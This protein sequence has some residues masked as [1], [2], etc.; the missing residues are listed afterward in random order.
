MNNLDMSD[1]Q[2]KHYIKRYFDNDVLDQESITTIY[3]IIRHN[4]GLN[5]IR[6][7]KSSNITGVFID[8]NKVSPTVLELI[9]N[10]IK[11]RI[12]SIAIK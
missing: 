8:L 6:D 7:S 1:R 9:V 10:V 11:K 4:D 5:P 2:K 3:R 12:E